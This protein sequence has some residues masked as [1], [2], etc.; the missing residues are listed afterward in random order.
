MDA[1][2]APYPDYHNEPSEI[3][4]AY[5]VALWEQPDQPDIDPE[6]LA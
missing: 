4:D 5:R 2:F 6:R 1:S 3:A